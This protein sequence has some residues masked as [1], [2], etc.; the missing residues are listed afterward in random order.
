M[1]KKT[2]EFYTLSE[3]IWH[4]LQALLMILLI[5]TGM[6]IH[7]PDRFALFGN[8][9]LAVR[10]HSIL[11]LVLLIN[12]FLGFFYQVSTA[13]I[14]RYLPM[15]MDFTRGS[16]EQ[17]KY[18]AWGIFRGVPHPYERTRDKRLNP[19]QK[20]TY[21]ALLNVLL[22]FQIFTGVL[23]WG[24]TRWPETFSKVGGLPF[25]APAHTLGSYLFLAFLIGH[26]YLTTTGETPLANMKAM[27]TG[28][29]EVH[30]D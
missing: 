14:R 9:A 23:C 17:I 29:E 7:F 15:P 1:N 28:Q 2:V 24:S 5:L 26:I 8:L 12:A 6:Q 3:R 16:L 27:I 11:A 22:P 25:L 21:F 30:E 10:L 20:I 13:G 18:Y 4:W 19:L